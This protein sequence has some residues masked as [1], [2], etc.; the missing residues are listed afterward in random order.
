MDQRNATILLNNVFNHSFEF[1]KFGIFIKELFNHLNIRP[2]SVP[3]WKEY[4]DYV[5]SVQSFG[6]YRDENKK[7]VEIFA[8]KLK[9]TGSRDRARTMQRNLVAKYLRNFNR[10]AALASFYGDDP[11][12]WRFSFIKMEYELFKDENGNLKVEEDLTPAKRYSFLVGEN[13]P[14]HTC[15]SQFLSLIKE[16][17]A[18]PSIENI[19]SAFS[20][21][22]V[23]KEFFNEYKNLYLDLKESLEKVIKKDPAVKEEF[24]KKHISTADFAKKLMGQIVFIYFLQK[25][26]WLGVKLGESWGTGSKNF[27]SHLF[28][29]KE[30]Y[31][32]FFN[33]ILEY[34]FY[35]A[36]A[37]DQYDDYHEKFKC[38]LPFL[39]GGLFEPIN[40]YDW[41]NTDITLD[42]KIFKKILNTFDRFNFTVK[43][44][45]PLEKEVAVDPEMLGKVFENLLDVTDRKSKGAYYTPREIVHYMCQQS[46]INYLNT[47]SN[48]PT[49]DIKEFIQLGDFALDLIIREKIKFSQPKK[50]KKYGLPTSIKENYEEI[51]ELLREIK[52]VDPAVGS[53]A[54][55]VGMMNEIVKARSILSI[56]FEDEKKS[57]D[58]KRETIENSLYGVDID[59][60][61]VDITKLRFWL[62]LIVDEDDVNNIKALPNLDH[63][64]MCG[65]SLLEEFEGLKLFD[66]KLLGEIPKDNSEI[67]KKLENKENALYSELGRIETGI[68]KDNG[69]KDEIKKELK[70]IERKKR[71]LS[72]KPKEIVIQP[73]LF[74]ERVTKSQI[75]L[76]KLKELQKQFF[77]EQNK[78]EKE[79]IRNNIEKIEWDLIEE[80]L[81]EE[82]NENAINKLQKYKIN[83]SKPFFLWNLYFAEVFQRENPGFD[84]VIANPPYIGFHGFEEIKP[85]LKEKYISATGKFDIYVPFIEKGLDL[86]R[87]EGTLTFIC[88][89]NFTK[90]NYGKKIRNFLKKEITILNIVDFEDF[91]IFEGALNYTGIFVFKK[92]IPQNDSLFC[93]KKRSIT[94]KG[95]NVIQDSLEEN[96]WVFHDPNTLK[97]I[98]KIK[99]QKSSLLGKLTFSISEG[100]VTGKNDVFLLNNED[101]EYLGLESELLKPCIRGRQIRKYNIN[102]VNET[103]IYPYEIVNGKTVPIPI[104]TIEKKYPNTFDYLTQKRDYLSGRGYFEKSTKNWYELW[105]QRSY[106]TQGV[107]KILVP[108]LAESNRF[109]LA[110][111]NLFYGD[112]VC[113]I[114]LKDTNYENILYTLGVLN[115]KLIEFLYKKTTVPKANQF[116]I[117]KTMFLKNIPIRE[118]DHSNS[119]ED[120]A[121]KK[122][123]SSVD[124][125]INIY[126]HSHSENKEIDNKIIQETDNQINNLIY[127]LYNL[128]NDEIEIINNHFKS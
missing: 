62:S 6:V 87:K 107:L 126:K 23:T 93:Y 13:E 4:E 66:E 9:K 69:R 91:Q 35:D 78:K 85:Y 101:V 27:L 40:G 124:K 94:H 57:Y 98:E 47:N 65:N 102:E 108:E 3:I 36:L 79:N 42:N 104:T 61:A 14:N 53:G 119:K 64:I 118:I 117:Y 32:N 75:K 41:R 2:R 25:K 43:E 84:V 5:E 128:N 113:G 83:E 46:L 60:S 106:D 63:K 114:K 92:T 72:L 89:T 86:I 100:I 125:L 48:V 95:F 21:E 56:F 68:L 34:L 10:N 11:D 15:K 116:Y 123:I 90:R 52:I 54:F 55:P 71:K 82:G 80:T 74:D 109:A 37:T 45:E 77:S 50:G 115:S 105:C 81:K 38:K 33:D 30:S 122:I 49:E 44:D 88:P 19:E 8:I 1:E 22:T 58:L 24:E 121:Y 29:K 26:G 7:T 96:G 28:E 103:I 31:T 16:E 12:D 110:E 112:T 17:D 120:A 18:D 127:Q 20:V 39:N 99:N 73:T 76:K 97:L 111:E 70:K 59:S 51:D 67:I